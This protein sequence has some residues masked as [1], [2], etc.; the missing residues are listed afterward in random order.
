MEA[1]PPDEPIKKK[2]PVA[3]RAKAAQPAPAADATIEPAAEFELLTDSTIDDEFENEQEA[4]RVLGAFALG[5][6]ILLLFCVIALLIAYR[7]VPEGL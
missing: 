1:T 4:T 3:R 7:N 2:P 6:M 5:L